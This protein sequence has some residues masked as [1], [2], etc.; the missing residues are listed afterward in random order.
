[1]FNP[2]QVQEHFQNEKKMKNEKKR[3]RKKVF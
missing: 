1:V 3:E 2:Q